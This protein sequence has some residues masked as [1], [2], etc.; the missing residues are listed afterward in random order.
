MPVGTLWDRQAMTD[1]GSGGHWRRN[2]ALGNTLF[3][4]ASGL[5]GANRLTMSASLHAL[6][7]SDHHRFGRIF[8]CGA[9]RNAQHKITEEERIFRSPLAPSRA[10]PYSI[11]WNEPCRILQSAFGI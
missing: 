1:G 3:F 7:P 6:A 4:L 2:R 5:E 8:K 9:W 10:Q 11:A